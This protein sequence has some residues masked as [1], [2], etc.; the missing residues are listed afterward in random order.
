MCIVECCETGS[1]RYQCTGGSGLEG[2]PASAPVRFSCKSAQNLCC[3]VFSGTCV[4]FTASP[5]LPRMLQALRHPRIR[6][7]TC[8]TWPHVS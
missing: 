8:K 6:A 4:H 7:T 1:W 3:M 5:P 2:G